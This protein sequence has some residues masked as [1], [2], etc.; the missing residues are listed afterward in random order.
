MHQIF[1]LNASSI[2]IPMEAKVPLRTKNGRPS[3][4]IKTK[5]NISDMI[6]SSRAELTVEDLREFE[7]WVS[8]TTA[9]KHI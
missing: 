4:T 9:K 8:T 3:I 6:K 5:I 7:I 1:F 2:A